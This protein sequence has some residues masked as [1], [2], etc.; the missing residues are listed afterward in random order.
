M[1]IFADYE[2]VDIILFDFLL[3][4][5]DDHILEYFTKFPNFHMNCTFKILNGTKL[6]E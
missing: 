1:Y 3:V 6:L 5:L 2:K 4:K